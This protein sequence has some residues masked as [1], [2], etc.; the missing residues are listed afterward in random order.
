MGRLKTKATGTRVRN[1]YMISNHFEM[2]DKL[3]ESGRRLLYYGGNTCLNFCE[4]D[5]Y[6]VAWVLKCCNFFYFV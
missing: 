1:G 6:E 4:L 5:A 3:D 2:S